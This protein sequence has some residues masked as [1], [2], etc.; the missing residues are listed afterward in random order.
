MARSA[1]NSAGL[2]AAA[3]LAAAL[4]CPLG[5]A[6]AQGV[7]IG[8]RALYPTD[9][10]QATHPEVPLAIRDAVQHITSGS[11]LIAVKPRIIG[12]EP[13]PTG[14]Y[15]WVASIELKGV[16]PRD[17]HFCGGAFMAPDWVITAAHCIKPDSADKIQVHS[18]SELD[19]GGNIYE[20]DRV[21]VN[22]KYDDG[23][24]DNDV[25]LVHLARRYAGPT[26]HLATAR[27]AQRD[28]GVAALAIALGWGLT[29]ENGAVSNILRRVTVQVVNNK[30]CNSVASYA[31]AITGTMMCAGLPEG[32]KDSCQGDSGGPLVVRDRDGFVQIG[33]VSWGEGCG[34]PLKFG[35][36]TRVSLI[37][38]WVA[39]H[40]GIRR[41]PVAAERPT[42]APP[43]TA[44]A[45]PERRAAPP[46][47]RSNSRVELSPNVRA[48]AKKPHRKRHQRA[49]AR[50]AR[51]EAHSADR[52]E[53]HEPANVLP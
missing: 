24:Q 8:P 31:G 47:V 2:T 37:E 43:Q 34:R 39:E 29:T 20:V 35:V 13:A 1:A 25:A 16:P 3:L 15:P 5:Q 12:G 4:A 45:P 7:Q 53:I 23:T 52:G 49:A 26:V 51:A 44:A 14:E 41:T 10:L 27:D 17:G 6:L 19:S 32:G 28:G 48:Q 36:Y 30:V 18:G 9:P 22:E 11:R 40:T 50:A 38:P 46:R 33:I 42:A 21:L